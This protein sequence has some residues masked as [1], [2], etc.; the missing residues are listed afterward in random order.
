L[1]GALRKL[2]VDSVDQNAVAGADF[3]DDENL[4]DDDD[5]SDFEDDIQEVRQYLKSHPWG[6]AVVQAVE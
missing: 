4:F 6:A 3:E 5:L 2:G 1:E